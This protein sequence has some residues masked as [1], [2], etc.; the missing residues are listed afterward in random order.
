MGHRSSVTFTLK[1]VDIFFGTTPILTRAN[2]SIRNLGITTVIGSSGSGK[3]TLLRTL[4]RLND[5]YQN[6]RCTGTVLYEGKNIYAEENGDL[7]IFLRL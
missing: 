2:V 7:E 6:F 3:S 4:N 1:D 5:H